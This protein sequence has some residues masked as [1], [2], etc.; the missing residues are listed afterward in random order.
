MGHGHCVA[1]PGYRCSTS[2]YRALAEWRRN[3]VD[4]LTGR[5]HLSTR[6]AALLEFCIREKLMLDGLDAWPL[7]QPSLITSGGRQSRSLDAMKPGLCAGPPA[8]FS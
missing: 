4:D 1:R 3:L 6:Q 7:A 2:L 5:E 8:W